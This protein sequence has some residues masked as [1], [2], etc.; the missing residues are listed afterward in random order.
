MADEL[1]Y[2]SEFDGSQIDALL[3]KVGLIA[4]YVVDQYITGDRNKWSWRKWNSG[5][6]E[7]WG[8][9]EFKIS[10]LI[11]WNALSGNDYNIYGHETREPLSFPENL[12]V[13]GTTGNVTMVNHVTGWASCRSL[14]N[15]SVYLRGYLTYTLT[16]DNTI[17]LGC[18]FKGMWK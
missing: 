13:R 9:F 10:A 5:V 17:I 7:C 1:K 6:S 3:N 18:S 8:W 15:T 16:G 11:E 12:F 14:G 4:D 2:T